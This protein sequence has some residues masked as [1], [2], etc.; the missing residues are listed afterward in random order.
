M[1]LTKELYDFS[2]IYKIK[3]YG[4]YTNV[5]KTTP[6]YFFCSGCNIKLKK[7][8]K[9]LTEYKDY[10]HISIWSSYCPKCFKSAH[11]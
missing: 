1:D 4:N 6:I 11:Y 7:S 5:K 2:D 8:F 10:S 9:K 3:L